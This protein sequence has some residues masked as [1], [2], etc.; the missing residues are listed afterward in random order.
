M[1]ALRVE[2]LC[3]RYSGGFALENVS[4]SLAEGSIMGL[5]GANGAGKTTTLKALMGYLRPGAGTV[6]LFG[7]PFPPENTVLRQRTGF[8]SGGVDYFP[9][10]RLSAITAATRPFYANWD[11]AV[12]MLA[13]E[14]LLRIVP[15]FARWCDR[16]DLAAQLHQLPVL[17]VGLAVYAL[18]TL[19]ALRISIR[20]F[21]RI[22]L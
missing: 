5:I 16:M 2:N 4:F 17:A 20:R 13:M 8:V 9:R 6:T 10:K 15:Y 3:K 22:D 21:A 19:W 14:I 7:Q 1:D 11:E 18:L 12:Y